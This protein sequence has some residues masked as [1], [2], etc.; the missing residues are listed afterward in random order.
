[1]MAKDCKE[2]C[3]SCR[4]LA[5]Y[6]PFLS[7]FLH[8]WNFLFSVGIFFFFS[9]V[10]LLF[11]FLHQ[12]CSSLFSPLSAGCNSGLVHGL[13]CFWPTVS[14]LLHFSSHPA[15]VS[16]TESSNH[17]LTFFCFPFLSPASLH[18]LLTFQQQ[19]FARILFC[20]PVSPTGMCCLHINITR[21]LIRT[22]LH[23]DSFLTS[24][25]ILSGQLWGKEAKIR[26]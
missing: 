21:G 3:R 5:S 11:L 18:L 10:L 15:L 14:L 22:C 24:N 19:S 4:S 23:K 7:H 1:M 17:F 6:L 26:H 25:T 12:P 2:K 8:A 20:S 9:V 13:I 16:R